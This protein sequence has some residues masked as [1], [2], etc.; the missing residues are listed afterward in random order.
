[1]GEHGRTIHIDFIVYEEQKLIE[2]IRERVYLDKSFWVLN[3][4]H[5]WSTYAC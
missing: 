2:S 1:M 3:M 4:R 5:K